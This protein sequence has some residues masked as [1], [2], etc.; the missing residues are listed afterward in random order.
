MKKPGAPSLPQAINKTKRLSGKSLH[1]ECFAWL[2]LPACGFGLKGVFG[3]EA[4]IPSLRNTPCP[5][6]GDRATISLG[7]ILT[8]PL[9]S[10]KTE[11]TFRLSYN[12]LYRKRRLQYSNLFF[13]QMPLHWTPKTQGYWRVHYHNRQITSLTYPSYPLTG[14]IKKAKMDST[15]LLLLGSLQV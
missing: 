8:S 1:L 13:S 10:D 15:L 14:M 7:S 2:P 4:R 3:R 12:S 6:R 5:L 11:V 9:H